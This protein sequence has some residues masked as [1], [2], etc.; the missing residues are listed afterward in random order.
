[1]AVA[2]G[3][4]LRLVAK[5][6][7]GGDDIQNVF[8][9]QVAG[10][11]FGTNDDVLD[12]VSE[13][14]DYAYTQ[15]DQY[16]SDNLNFDS[17]EGYNVTQEEYLGEQTWPTLVQGGSADEEIP[18]QCAPLCLF[19]TEV[20]KSQG[21]KFLPPLIKTHIDSDGTISGTALAAI[22]LFC[23]S[24]LAGVDEGTWTA[25]FG[26]YRPLGEIFIEWV[27]AVAR[28]F[29]ATQRRRYQGKGS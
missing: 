5:M 18:P 9:V 22:Y 6:S 23:T 27:S 29:F 16:L 2:D 28:D 13:Q 20:A 24:I 26:N 8:H 25:V 4:V 12:A 1:M 15:F 17:I 11:G 21:R 14:I 19:L 7:N 10:T 3:D